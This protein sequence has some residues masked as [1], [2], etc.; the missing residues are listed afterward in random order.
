MLEKCSWKVSFFKFAK[1]LI[2]ID[3]LLIIN[4]IYGVFSVSK[5]FIIEILNRCLK[6]WSEKIKH[7]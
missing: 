6:K 4:F 1:T 2:E 7:V 3:N 5:E